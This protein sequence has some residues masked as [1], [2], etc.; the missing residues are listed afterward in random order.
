M[1][2]EKTTR[3]L[4]Q[5]ANKRGQKQLI[6]VQKSLVT[7]CSPLTPFPPSGKAEGRF[8]VGIALS[9]SKS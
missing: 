7:P 6:D 4:R 3:Y 2:D 9:L 8:T 1:Q 5:L